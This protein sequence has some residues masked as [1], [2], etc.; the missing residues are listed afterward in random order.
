MNRIPRLCVSI[1]VAAVVLTAG[2]AAFAAT[3]NVTTGQFLVAVAKVHH[4][5]AADPAAAAGSL[6]AAGYALPE[7]RFDNTLTEGSV[8]SIA[9]ALGL[10]VTTQ[11]PQAIFTP[12]Q[13]DA[14]LNSF[15]Q[16]LGNRAA[17]DPT[18]TASDPL[19]KGKGKKKGLTKS[20]SE[21]L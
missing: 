2:A 4:L 20:R 18:T 3:D 15:G 6:R 7:L 14:F 17:S 11:N 21:P 1:L 13:V 10:R 9:S 19:T 12:S 8:A 5:D 16:E